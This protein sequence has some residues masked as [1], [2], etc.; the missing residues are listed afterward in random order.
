MGSKGGNY[1]KSGGSGLSA[2]LSRMMMGQN[3]MVSDFRYVPPPRTVSASDDDGDRDGRRHGTVGLGT[4]FP[5][6]ILKFEMADHPDGLVC[7]KGAFL[8]GSHTVVVEMSYAK[9]IAGGFFGGEGFVLQGLR[10]TELPSSRP[11]GR[12]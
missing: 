1:S 10:G 9:S 7:Q 6:K 2:G 3:L 8:A 12:S 11:T 4:D 5:A